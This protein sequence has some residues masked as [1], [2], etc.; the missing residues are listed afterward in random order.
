VYTQHLPPECIKSVILGERTSISEQREI[1][2]TVKDSRTTLA[3]AAIDHRGYAFRCEPIKMDVP[4]SEMSPW[5]TP[6]TAHI[7]SHLE[8]PF[9]EVTRH[10]IAHHPMSNTVNKR[11]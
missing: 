6:R 4:V 11:V 10:L 9:G 3:L 7:F 8:T 1:Y 2:E 5:I